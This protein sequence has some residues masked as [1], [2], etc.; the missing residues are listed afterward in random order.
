MVSKVPVTWESITLS[1]TLTALESAV[2]RFVAVSVHG[3]SFTL[4][5]EQTSRRREME[6]L[7]SCDLAAIWLEMGVDEF[8]VRLRLVKMRERERERE[9]ENNSYS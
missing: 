2:E 5:A 9:K 3:M 8:A 6:G 4:V 7:A 1:G